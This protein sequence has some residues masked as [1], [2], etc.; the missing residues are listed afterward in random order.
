MT[1][2]QQK[3]TIKTILKL[4]EFYIDDRKL[5]KFEAINSDKLIKLIMNDERVND[6]V[7]KKLSRIYYKNICCLQNIIEK[8]LGG[9]I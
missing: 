6:E 9:V 8:R 3:T 5:T 7:T 4:T 1:K 2:E